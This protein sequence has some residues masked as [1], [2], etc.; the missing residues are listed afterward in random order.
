MLYWVL[1]SRLAALKQDGRLKR[2]SETQTLALSV[3]FPLAVLL[4]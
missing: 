4:V 3:V 2:D 1:F